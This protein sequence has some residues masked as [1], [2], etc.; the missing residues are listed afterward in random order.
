MSA[1]FIAPRP[2]LSGLNC[3]IIAP[4]TRRP[5]IPFRLFQFFFL[6][7]GFRSWSFHPAPG[8]SKNDSAASIY[9]IITHSRETIPVYY[10]TIIIYPRPSRRTFESVLLFFFLFF[11][12]M[13]SS[14]TTDFT[15]NLNAS[16]KIVL[17]KKLLL[18][19]AHKVI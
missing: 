4:K 1:S 5:R 13:R 6:G 12:T 2:V 19:L 16:P 8:R 14:R 15:P 3:A 7:G 9:V 18:S 11:N 17:P 10:M